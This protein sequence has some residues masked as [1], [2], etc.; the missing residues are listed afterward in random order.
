MIIPFAFLLGSLV[1]LFY[2]SKEEVTL[3]NDLSNEVIEE[4]NEIYKDLEDL[5]I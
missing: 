1:F 2:K 5:F 3:V 4:E